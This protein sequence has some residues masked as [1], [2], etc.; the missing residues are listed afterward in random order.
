MNPS[1]VK[2][3]LLLAAAVALQGCIGRDVPSAKPAA[4]PVQQSLAYHDLDGTWS[5]GRATSSEFR[6]TTVTLTTVT[7]E[8]GHAQA[9]VRASYEL[10]GSELRMT[11]QG[12][13]YESNPGNPGGAIEE[14]HPDLVTVDRISQFTGT[15][16]H[17]ERVALYL[18]GRMQPA[19]S[20]IGT[21]NDC[22]RSS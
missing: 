1:P 8:K 15:S 13:R 16:F 10:D 14:A 9:V 17:T 3:L 6:E 7:S 21:G 11:V 12:V 20:S 18:D 19:H 2:P 22:T 4:A 5:C